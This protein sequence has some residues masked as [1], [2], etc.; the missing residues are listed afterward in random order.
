MKRFILPL[1]ILTAAVASAAEP[2]IC[3]TAGRRLIY[4]ESI[5]GVR[6]GTLDK[7]VASDDNGEITLTYTKENNPIVERWRIYP[8][9]TVLQIEVPAEMQALLDTLQVRDVDFRTRNLALPAEMNPG[10]LFPGF[11]FSVS[12]TR[13]DERTTLSVR[14]DS[15]R[16]AS[17]GPIRTPGWCRLLSFHPISHAGKFDA[18]RLEF[19]TLTTL[20]DQEVAGRMIQWMAPGIGLVRQEI[21]VCEGV[22][23]VMGLKKITQ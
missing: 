19:R 18:V 23:S 1:M 9:S 6:T 4:E 14:S 2:W 7:L 16:V 13:G 17:C 15:V 12:G 11:G 3:T 22:A 10:D 5:G 20:G 21:P 8:D